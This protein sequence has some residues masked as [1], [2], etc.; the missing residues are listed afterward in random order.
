MEFIDNIEWA[1]LQGLPGLGSGGVRKLL[2][3]YTD[4][5]T[6]WQAIK[7]NDSNLL[8]NGVLSNNL[9]TAYR[10]MDLD[11]YAAAMQTVMNNMHIGVISYT[12]N[13]FPEVLS[14]IYNPPAV[15]FYKGNIDLLKNLEYSISIVGARACS[16]YGKNVCF[17]FAQVLASHGITIVSG[18]A[19]GIDSFAHEGTLSSKG[20][21]IAIMGC[22]LNV[23]YP[24]ENARLFR[25]IVEAGGL[26]LSEFAPGMKPLKQNF[27]I[28]NRLIA[29]LTK[30]TIVVEAKASSGSLITADMAI[31]EGR[32]VFTVP[33]NVL[34]GYSDGSNWL[35][36]Q[37]ANVMTKPEDLLSIMGWEK[38][39]YSNIYNK[40]S[41]NKDDMISL[42]MEA[43]A[44]ISSLS[45]EK[46]YTL[47]D[48]VSKTMLPLPK[49]Q[50]ILLSLELNKRIEKA[51]GQGY[52]LKYSRRD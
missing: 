20:K 21:T 44:I 19:R 24:R 47:E 29:G 31:N 12:N 43:Q 22:G 52:V 15:L 5:M 6:A 51:N 7:K 34:S 14:E 49:V 8:A 36:K 1:Y 37:G 13:Y 26:L 35:L 45:T 9:L 33:G 17:H 4:V 2:T 16:P 42:S 11:I 23:V 10:K 38:L 25:Q 40:G 27:P 50:Q 39:L 30:G 46:A 48:I 28:R 41:H 32:E 3:Y 18:G